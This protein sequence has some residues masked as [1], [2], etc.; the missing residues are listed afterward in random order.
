MPQLGEVCFIFLRDKGYLKTY[1]DRPT[2]S[3]TKKYITHITF[4]RIQTQLTTS[5]QQFEN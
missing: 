3:S 1:Q 2:S 5:E 4:F